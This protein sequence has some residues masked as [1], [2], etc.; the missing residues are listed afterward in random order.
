MPVNLNDVT[1]WL[2][3]LG[4]VNRSRADEIGQTDAGLVVTEWANYARGENP[5][6]AEQLD[7][8][9]GDDPDRLIVSY[10]SIGE[11]ENYRYYWD[12]AWEDN[13]P[14]WLDEPN[15]QWTDNILVRYWEPAWQEIIFDYV[16]RIID[17]GFN[18][19]YLDIIE[20]Y[21]YWEET[22]PNSGIRYRRE[23]AD[24]VA[25]IRAHAEE[26]LAEVDPGRDFVIIGQN[27]LELLRN[28]T[29][30]DAIDGVAREDLRFYYEYGDEAGFEEWPNSEYNYHLDLLEMAEEYGI[31]AFVVEYIPS[32]HEGTARR[33]LIRE[34]GDL[35]RLDI[36]LYVAEDRDLDQI[37]ERP[38]YLDGGGSSIQGTAGADR[39]TGTADDDLIDGRAGGDTIRAGDGNDTARGGTGNDRIFGEDGRDI[40][41]GDD[42]LD[43]LS[44][45]KG[46]DVLIGGAGSDLLEGGVGRDRL[47]GDAGSD[48]LFGDAGNDI[49]IGGRGGDLLEGGGGAD[50][51]VFGRRS[52]EDEITDFDVTADRI[53]LQDGIDYEVFRDGANTYIAFGEN[54]GVVLIGVSRGDFTDDL[55]G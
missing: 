7:R 11:A 1:S 47:R 2:Y 15:G 24:F 10:L 49:L 22:E 35:D 51:F 29:Y 20:G 17:G 13:P 19:L 14:A 50:T 3:H 31:A 25:R 44:G 46:G 8:M 36:P 6:T 28:E 33:S 30:R 32:Q 53:V 18:G 9:R 34:A 38:G 4:D 45:G 43:E 42:G 54:D 16:D 39:I 23:M 27:G 48:E 41:F 55:I 52:G 37:I 21:E 12:D 40:L 5:Y 26:R